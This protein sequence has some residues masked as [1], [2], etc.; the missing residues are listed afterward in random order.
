MDRIVLCGRQDKDLGICWKAL[1]AFSPGCDGIYCMKYHHGST[2]VWS[3]LCSDLHLYEIDLHCISSSYVQVWVLYHMHLR[4]ILVAMFVYLSHGSSLYWYAAMMKTHLLMSQKYWC[5]ADALLMLIPDQADSWLVVITFSIKY[6]VY[7]IPL[8][9]CFG[10]HS[11]T[12]KSRH[13]HVII[14]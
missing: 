5:I 7:R 13:Q 6:L 11:I 8:A 14:S 9:S 2:I 10:G 4:F 3:W 12:P 1:I